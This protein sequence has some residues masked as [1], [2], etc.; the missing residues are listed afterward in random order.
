MRWTASCITWRSASGSFR[1]AGSAR[2]SRARRPRRSRAARSRDRRLRGVAAHRIGDAA[3]HV[4]ARI[5]G[6]AD[7]RHAGCGARGG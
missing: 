5:H 1:A 7:V 6:D 3:G 4:S 2:D